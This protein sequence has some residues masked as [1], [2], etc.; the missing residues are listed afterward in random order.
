MN[1]LS[2]LLFNLVL[3]CVVRGVKKNWSLVGK[4]I[5]LD[6]TDNLNLVGAHKMDVIRNAKTPIEG[7][8]EVN[9]K[10]K[11]RYMIVTKEG[12]QRNRG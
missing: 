1:A 11:I 12:I 10:V 2:T 9:V 8:K 3:N 5:T 6:Y 4:S 7:G